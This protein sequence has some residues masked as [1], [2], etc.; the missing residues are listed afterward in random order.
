MLTMG[1]F[2]L[3]TIFIMQHGHPY[4]SAMVNNGSLHYA[5]ETDGMHTSLGGCQTNIRRK[6]HET[7]VAVRYEHNQL[8]VRR[9]VY[10]YFY[11]L[12]HALC[13]SIDTTYHHRHHHRHLVCFLDSNNS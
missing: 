2:T 8:M 3:C 4:I 1:T 6:T 9:Y 7:F 10:D 12:M 11:F 13:F 5:H